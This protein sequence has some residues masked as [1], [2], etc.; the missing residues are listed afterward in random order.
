ML[1]VHL[2]IRHPLPRVQRSEHS[3]RYTVGTQSVLALFLENLLPGGAP[4]GNSCE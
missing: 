1:C 4:G 3:A 2:S